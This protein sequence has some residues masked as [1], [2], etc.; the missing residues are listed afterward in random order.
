MVHNVEKFNFYLD[1]FVIDLE[2]KMIFDREYKIFMKF[3]NFKKYIDQYFFINIFIQNINTNIID[4]INKKN[5]RLFGE[6]N[7]NNYYLESIFNK[8]NIIW[9]DFNIE[10]QN[11]I[12]GYLK[13][14]VYYSK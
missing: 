6:I 12:W 10:E 11:Y 7:I 5:S 2:K 9:N 8:I 14:L 1:E 3:Y 4:L 13:I